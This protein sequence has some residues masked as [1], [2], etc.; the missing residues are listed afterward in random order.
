MLRYLHLAITVAIGT[1]LNAQEPMRLETRN[2]AGTATARLIINSGIDT[3]DVKI[4][5]SRLVLTSN[6][7][8]SFPLVLKALNGNSELSMSLKLVAGSNTRIA[9]A[10]NSGIEV[11]SMSES[12][13]LQSAFVATGESRFLELP[14]NGTNYVGLRAP[15]SVSTNTIWKLPAADGLSGQVLTTDGAGN[16]SWSSLGGTVTQINTGAGLT[17]GPITS[18]GTISVATGGIS[19]SMLQNSSVTITAGNGL[20]GGGSV[21][22]GESV[23]ISNAGVLTVT[24][25]GVLSSSGGQN[26]NISLTGVVGI[27]NGGTANTTYST[28]KFLAFDGTKISSTSFDGT[29]FAAAN[30]AHATLTAGAG[31]TGGTYNGSSAA[32]FAVDF[33]GST[34]VANSAAR[35]DHTHTNSPSIG[36]P[37]VL[38]DGEILKLIRGTINADG[39]TKHG[40]GFTSA[41]KVVGGVPQ[42]GL[43]VI[44]FTK[45]FGGAP[46]VTANPFFNAISI[47][48]DDNDD[49]GKIHPSQ[50]LSVVVAS[51]TAGSI[52]IAIFD[53]RGKLVDSD[54]CFI[55]T[56][57]N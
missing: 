21:P 39:T 5:K 40:G 26:P 53:H 23:T 16:L 27:A 44:T 33:T 56:G 24:A 14:S 11:I 32:T 13:T 51:T 15:D 30:H 52:E 22:L 31:L 41:K 6:A 18:S 54:F 28:G 1:S 10:N 43:Y 35:S 45:A 55:A 7:G 49:N 2:A 48:D 38:S 17:G 29:S 25:S 3:A 9:V 19:N 47:K 46:S 4:S 34:G 36:G 42:K 8:E 50:R 20:S 37:Y 12:G 57:P